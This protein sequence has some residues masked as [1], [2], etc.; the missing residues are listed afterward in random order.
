M[1]L[2]GGSNKVHYFL[3]KSDFSFPLERGIK[4]RSLQRITLE[5]STTRG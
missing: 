5:T 1:S 4:M 3:K 2:K